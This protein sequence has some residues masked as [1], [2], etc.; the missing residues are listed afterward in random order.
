LTWWVAALAPRLANV[1]EL[2]AR[3][4][5]VELNC[6]IDSDGDVMHVE[7]DILRALADLGVRI[8]LEILPRP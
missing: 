8:A 5:A 6:Y 2:T 7:P 4:W 3:G 1:R